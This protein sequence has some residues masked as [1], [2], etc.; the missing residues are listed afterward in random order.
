MRSRSGTEQ[1]VRV[2]GVGDP[3]PHGIVD[4]VFERGAAAADDVQRGAEEFHALDVLLLP[5][6][7]H[8]AHVD[9]DG[10]AQQRADH[11][12]RYSVLTGAGLGN[13]PILAKSAGQ[14]A[15]TDRV[16]GLMRPSMQQVF[17][18]QVDPPTAALREVL[19]QVQRRRS[20]GVVLEQAVKLRH[21]AFVFLGVQKAGF[22]LMQRRH[23]RLRHVHASV[24]AIARRSDHARASSKNCSSLPW[25]LMPGR[26][27]TPLQ[28]SIAY[29]FNCRAPRTLSA[30]IPPERKTLSS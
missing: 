3:I 11:G 18:L 29:G 17:A 14:Q 15:L 16:V 21:E 1:V 24:L 13:D 23:Q 25:S 30:S 19:G 2:F 4:G 27:S 10:D 9:L 8:R 7:I 12:R 26:D 28:T 6:N 5:L 20:A 22:D